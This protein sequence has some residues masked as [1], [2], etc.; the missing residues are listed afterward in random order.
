MRNNQNQRL[1]VETGRQNGVIRGE[2]L[3]SDST[4]VRTITL[5][6]NKDKDKSITCSL[7]ISCDPR[8]INVSK[9]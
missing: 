5:C 8:K 7:T 4:C 1:S 9:V 3:G 2:R 6:Q